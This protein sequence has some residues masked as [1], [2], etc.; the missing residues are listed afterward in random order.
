MNITSHLNSTEELIGYLFLGG[1]SLSLHGY[2]LFLCA[3][4]FDYQDEKPDQE[5]SSFDF[6]IKDLM[7]SQFWS[8]YGW[9]LIHIIAI[10]NIGCEL[11]KKNNECQQDYGKS[12]QFHFLK[13]SYSK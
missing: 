1:I 3:A 13:W 12:S 9:V 4:I 11:R 2:A 8:L 7:N 5:K 6:L 10:G